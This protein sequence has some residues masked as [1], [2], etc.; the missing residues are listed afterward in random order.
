MILLPQSPGAGIICMCH[1]AHFDLDP[2]MQLTGR[3]QPENITDSVFLIT[4]ILHSRKGSTSETVK[5]SVI[6]R[7]QRDGKKDE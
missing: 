1:P 6:A 7:G 2:L 5:R 4:C 3:E